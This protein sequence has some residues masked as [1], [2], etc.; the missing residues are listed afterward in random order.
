MLTFHRGSYVIDV[1]VRHHQRGAAQPIAPYAYFQ[2]TRD[3][4]QAVVQSSMAPAA[5]V[6]PVVYNDKDNFKKVE[7]AEIDKLAAEPNRKPLVHDQSADNGWVGMIEH[8]FVAAW[9]PSD[10]TK[11]P[12]EFYTRKLDGGLYTA[13]VIVPVGTDRAG[14]D[15]RGARARCTSARRTRTCSPRPR[16]ASTSSSTTASS[17][18]SPR[19]CSAAASGCTG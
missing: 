3:T 18:C 6:G 9:L 19:R 2:L 1:A 13:G 7:F 8:Y 14:R 11:A 16:R 15:R 10:E 5:Y 17:P 4:K 12:R